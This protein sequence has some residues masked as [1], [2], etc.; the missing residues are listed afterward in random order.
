MTLEI[1]Q[2]PCRSDNFGVIIHDTASGATASI[3]APEEKAIRDKLVEK[4]WRL[5]SIFTTH[6]HGDHTEGNLPLKADFKAIITGPAGEATKIPGIDKTVKEGDSFG[7]GDFEVRVIAT[8]G[9]TLG[10]I[11][12]WIPDAGV[13]FVGDTLFA[14]GCGRIAEGTPEMMWESLS[15]LAA[16]PDETVIYC[17]HEYTEANA[18]FALTIEPGNADL[19]KRAAEVGRLR[20]AGK[21]TLPTTIGLEKKTNPF[22]RANEPAVRAAVGLPNAPAAEVFGEVRKRKDSFK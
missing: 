12:Y 21:P 8:P 20:A 16:L 5:D 9:H 22:L 4:K 7:F 6:H 1:E 13:A 11:A 19:V 17:G 2:F 18:R 3:D 14:I 15:K 10:H